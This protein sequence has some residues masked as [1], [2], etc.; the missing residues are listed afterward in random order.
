M[1]HILLADDEDRNLQA[2]KILLKG[3]GHN[4][5]LAHSAVE[6]LDLLKIHHFDLCIVDLI[7]P[8]VDGL[9]LIRQI[10]ATPHLAHLLILVFSVKLRTS[11]VAE[12]LDAGA[13]DYLRK[14]FEIVELPARVRALLRRVPGGTLDVG[15]DHLVLGDLRLNIISLEVQAGRQ[16]IELTGLE[17]QLL[18]Y[19]MRHPGQPIPTQR[20][21]EDIWRYPPGVGNPNVVQVHI[22]NLRNKLAAVSTRRYIRNVRGKGYVISP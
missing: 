16:T 22:T 7:M 9:S 2:I 20:F 15:N 17:H 5:V 10:R 13:D 14:P 12:G 6:A 8:E 11:E 18:Y 19:L 4:I 3:Q 21:L 1:A